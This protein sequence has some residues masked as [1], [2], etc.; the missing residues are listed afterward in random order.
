[1]IGTRRRHGAGRLPE[2]AAPPRRGLAGPARAARS[3]S[4]TAASAAT[5]P[6]RTP[7]PRCWR[8]CTASTVHLR[9]G[10]TRHR[11]RRLH[12]RVDPRPGRQDRGR[13]ARTSCRPSRARSS[14]EEIIELIAFIKSLQPRRDARARRGLTRRPSTT[15]PITPPKA[16]SHEHRHPGI[17]SRRPP[18]AARASRGENYLNVAHGVL[19][20]LLTKDHKRIAHPLP[21]HGHAHVLHRRRGHHHRP[22]AT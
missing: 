11:R 20:W 19:S 9:D 21:D 8:N 16:E 2:L 18:A 3:S 1:M 15:P 14:E 22:P 5:A 13:L 10:R 4:S 6:T 17:R 12:P 7:A